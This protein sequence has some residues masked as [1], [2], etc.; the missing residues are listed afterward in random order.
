MQLPS[1]KAHA[2]LLVVRLAVSFG[3]SSLSIEGDSLITVLAINDPF[4]F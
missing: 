1:R 4:L 3:C 2:A